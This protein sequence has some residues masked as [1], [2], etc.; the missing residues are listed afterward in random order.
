MNDDRFEDELPGQLL[1]SLRDYNAPPETPRE[2]IWAR[3]EARRRSER[4]VLGEKRP[5]FWSRRRLWWPAAA[6]AVLTVGIVIGRIS[7]PSGP[8]PSP[9]G[10]E[11]ALNGG[12]PAAGDTG[13]VRFARN[14]PQP[15]TGPSAFQL[16]A[17]PVLNQAELLLT[18]FR[19]GET[20]N[21]D[22]LTFTERAAGLLSDTRLLLDS[23]AV[24]DPELRSLLGDLEL[25]LA[26]IVRIASEN[27][28]DDRELINKSLEDRS[29]LPRL[30]TKVPN[31]SLAAYI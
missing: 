21:G 26:R 24:D 18:Q 8:P 1:E 10:R 13:A 2:T 25:I 6:A 7:M 17:V 4:V 30:R 29:I 9:T 28:E 23:P 22:D 15:F 19:T 20:A 3:I 11:A 27:P 5:S 14:R 31:S 16:A 12:G